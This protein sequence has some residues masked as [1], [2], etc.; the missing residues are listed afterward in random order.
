MDRIVVFLHVAAMF[1]AVG[2]SVVPEILMHRL[3]DKGDVR[4]VRSFGGVFRS[5][6]RSIPIL[7][8]GGTVLGLVAVA[9][10]PGYDY[11]QMWLVIAYLLVAIGLVLGGAIQGPW[12]NRLVQ[13][14]ITSP[15]D[16]PSAEFRAIAADPRAK[17][18]LYGGVLATVLA[19]LDMVVKP[20]LGS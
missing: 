11:T 7:F 13:A 19:I 17:M 8:V 1:A 4:G 6:A 20:G 5:F 3:A 18:A 14:A 9:L 10:I 15:E 12:G 16:Q 2:V